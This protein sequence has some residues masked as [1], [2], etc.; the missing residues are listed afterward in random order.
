VNGGRA[1]FDETCAASDHQINFI[2]EIEW[3][4][5]N[6]Q[7]RRDLYFNC[8]FFINIVDK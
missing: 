4:D 7:L 8:F 2:I 1:S 3:M 5:E 6:N